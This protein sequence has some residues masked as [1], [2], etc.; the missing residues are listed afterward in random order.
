MDNERSG[1][2]N[3]GSDAVTSAPAEIAEEKASLGA[4]A[5]AALSKVSGAAQQAENHAKGGGNI[6]RHGGR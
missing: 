3:S 2:T 6:A 5:G 1:S 4:Q